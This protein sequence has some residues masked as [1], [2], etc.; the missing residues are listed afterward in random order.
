ML[1]IQVKVFVVGSST[2]IWWL[3][4]SWLKRESEG[5]YDNRYTGV[6]RDEKVSVMEQKAR[7][8]FVLLTDCCAPFA[9]G[10]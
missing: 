6:L 1:H 10:A 3:L 8:K 7:L 5:N 4:Q 2:R 9:I